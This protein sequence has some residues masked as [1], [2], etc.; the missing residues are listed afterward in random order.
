[1]HQQE[2]L[3]SIAAAGMGRSSIQELSLGEQHRYRQRQIHTCDSS[4]HQE[5]RQ[6]LVA[7]RKRQRHC[8]LHTPRVAERLV[9]GLAVR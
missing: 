6:S 5:K 3:C 9:E 1:M 8:K 2:D 7:V 4:Q